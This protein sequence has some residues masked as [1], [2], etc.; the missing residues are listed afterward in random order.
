MNLPFD[1][2]GLKA[3]HRT[4]AAIP[5]GKGNPMNLSL[6]TLICVQGSSTY[7]KAQEILGAIKKNQVPGSANNDGSG[8]MPFKVIA[9]P[10][11][12]VTNTEYWVML[13]SS[14]IGPEFG[15][16]FL[17]SQPITLSEPNIEI[18]RAHV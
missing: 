1:Y 2:S 5:D 13:D 8:V 15:W 10:P 11:L 3:A 12:Y 17:E 4:A 16:Q 6:D 9:L 18:G 7:F 14:K